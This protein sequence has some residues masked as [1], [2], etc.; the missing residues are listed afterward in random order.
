MAHHHSYW[1]MGLKAKVRR[2]LPVLADG[3]LDIYIGTGG[4]AVE[5][6]D[7][8][9]KPQWLFTFLYGTPMSLVLADVRPD[10]ADPCSLFANLFLD[11]LL[12]RVRIQSP[13][14]RG[15]PDLEFVPV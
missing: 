2:I 3:K 4:S 12:R 15:I 14:V 8:N 10:H 6:L 1:T 13:Q 11:F 5:R 9:G 7:E